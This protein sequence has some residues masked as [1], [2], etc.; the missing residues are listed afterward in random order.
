MNQLER[1]L[2]ALKLEKVDR[3]PCASPLQT[4]T[5]DLMKA[6]GAYWP[7]AHDDP[8]LMAKLALAA[9]TMGGIESVRVPFD[10]AVDATAF[11][12]IAGKA[13]RLT[14]PMLL[15]RPFSNP[16][17][18]E[19]A[20]VPDPRKSGR[21]PV[22]LE[23]VKKL[24]DTLK[25]E[26]PVIAAITSTFMLAC[27]LRGDEAGIMDVIKRPQTIESVLQLACE[28]NIAYAEELLDAGADIITLVDATSSG[29]ILGPKQYERFAMPYQKK[30]ADA[31]RKKGALT[32]LH[33][34]G[35]TS[36]NLEY[37]V[38]TGVNGISVDQSMNLK[39]V[40]EVLAGRAAVVGNVDPTNTLVRKKPEDVEAEVK[41]C[42]EDGTNIVAPGCGFSPETPLENMKAMVEATKRYG[43]V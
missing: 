16:E 41:R 11:G 33:I 42:I 43:A 38:T 12:T 6:T 17:K 28:W 22:V 3:L 14:Q 25:D 34:C 2:A 35:N 4:G 15:D 24:K 19:S 23:A 26:V 5:E 29:D 7:E 1:L 20:E 9:H 31:V 27:Q 18:I 39:K 21:A 30:I 37:M 13:T 10:V 40:R 36:K 8:E 32:V